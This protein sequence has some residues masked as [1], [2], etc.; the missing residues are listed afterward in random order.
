MRSWHPYAYLAFFLILDAAFLFFVASDLSISADEAFNYFNSQEAST[1]MAHFFTDIFGQND[2]ALRGGFIF[3]HILTVLMVFVNARFYT[4]KTQDRVYTA[5]LYALLPV[6]NVGAIIV[7]NAQIL[8]FCLMF[9]IYLTKTHPKSSYAFLP[10]FLMVD[11][12]V[13]MLYGALVVYALLR[14]NRFLLVWAGILVCIALWL[15]P[16]DFGPKPSGF[17][18]DNMGTFMAGFSPFIFVYMVYA[19]YRKIIER[20]IDAVLCVAAC[21]LFFTLLLSIRQRLPL[22]DFLPFMTLGIFALVSIFLK[23]YRIR[24]VPFRKKYLLFFYCCMFFLLM[25]LFLLSNNK[26][27]YRFYSNKSHHFA[28]NYHVVKELAYELKKRGITQ[29]LTNNNLQDRLRFYGIQRGGQPLLTNRKK[30]QEMIE[31]IY[32]NTIVRRFYI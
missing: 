26:A 22:E 8:V 4:S 31:I 13:Y 19:I 28:Y 21:S 30:F 16:F 7:N 17:L 12:S 9:Y 23:A 11:N 15:Q 24:L 5:I 10:L 3:L 32:Y 29:V 20:K 1:Y 2:L 25:Y 18:L 6:V 27:F 14:K